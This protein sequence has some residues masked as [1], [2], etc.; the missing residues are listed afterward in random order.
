M[1]K[2]AGFTLVELM[3]VFAVIAILVT[4]SLPATIGWLHDYRLKQ[5]AKDLYGNMQVTRMG[6]IKNKNDWSMYRAASTMFVRRMARMMTG[7]RS[8]ATPLNGPS[9]WAITAAV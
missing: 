5:A 2:N 1:K 6:A 8:A 9:P 4:I 3:V 7:R